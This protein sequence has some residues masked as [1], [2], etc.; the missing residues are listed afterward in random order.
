VPPVI[1]TELDEI[2]LGPLI[3]SPG[4]PTPLSPHDE[5]LPQSP[6]GWGS[7][8]NEL[9]SYC[10]ERLLAHSELVDTNLERA[11]EVLTD[12]KKVILTASDS[13]EP[14]TLLLQA[15]VL[16]AEALQNYAA[17][18]AAANARPWS[19][20]S[21]ALDVRQAARALEIALHACRLTEDALEALQSEQSKQIEQSNQIEQSKQSQQIKQS[22][23]HFYSS[24]A[25][26]VRPKTNFYEDL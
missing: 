13:S 11:A 14:P 5:S 4:A 18:V 16:G 15:R 1:L 25:K 22:L 24:H 7:D 23:Y 17:A 20:C 12:V 26:N 9:E 3:T 6:D 19:D 8:K 21:A 2:K 10:K